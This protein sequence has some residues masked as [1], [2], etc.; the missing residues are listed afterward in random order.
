M[1]SKF[2]EKPSVIRG[3]LSVGSKKDS[4]SK[5]RFD[6]M[7]VQIMW[8]FGQQTYFSTGPSPKQGGGSKSPFNAI[9]E[10]STYFIIKLGIRRKN[11]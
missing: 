10:Y 3:R 4:D 11:W 7:R 5:P 9:P 1:D 6:R 8:G 2:Y